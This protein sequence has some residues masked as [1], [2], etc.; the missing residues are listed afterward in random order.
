MTNS[1]NEHGAS[2]VSDGWTNVKGK[3]LISVLAVS[4]GGAIFLLAYDYSEK[5]NTPI[6]IA[7]PLL[8]IIEHIGPYNVIQVIIANASNCKAVGAIIEDK[9]PN[10]FWSGCLVHTMNLLMH[11]IIE[12]KHLQAPFE[13]KRVIG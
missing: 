3:P 6:N 11:D 8:Q 10:T 12:N 2:I 7:E 5:F 13:G 9:Y 4:T 1:W